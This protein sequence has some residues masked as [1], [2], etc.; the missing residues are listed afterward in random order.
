VPPAL[1]SGQVVASEVAKLF[2][3]DWVNLKLRIWRFFQ[4]KNF[5]MSFIL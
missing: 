2:P 5:L 4:M 1:I 3:L